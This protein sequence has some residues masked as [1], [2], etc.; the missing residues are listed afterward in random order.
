MK[1]IGILFLMSLI[2]LQSFSKWVIIA[3]YQINKGYIASTQ[4]INRN[5]PKMHCN[6]KCQMMKKLAEEEK[7]NAPTGPATTKMQEPCIIQDFR[8]SDAAAFVRTVVEHHSCYQQS[9]SLHMPSSVFHPPA[10]A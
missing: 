2:L 10:L 9:Y 1:G 7:K 5:L 4:C 3:E 6:G 8:V